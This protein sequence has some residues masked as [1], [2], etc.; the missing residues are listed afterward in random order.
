[1]DLEGKEL[2]LRLR[3]MLNDPAAASRKILLR[4]VSV[5]NPL[6]SDN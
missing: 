5:S 6:L 1:M 4:G 2:F 3:K